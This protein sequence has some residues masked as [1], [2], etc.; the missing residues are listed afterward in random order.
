MQYAHGLSLRSV[1]VGCFGTFLTYRLCGM[2]V[3]V[4][5]EG[6]YGEVLGLRADWI[7][8]EAGVKLYEHCHGRGVRENA[9]GAGAV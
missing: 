3:A 1:A 7:D 8:R 2:F 6:R 4:S 9:R 5:G